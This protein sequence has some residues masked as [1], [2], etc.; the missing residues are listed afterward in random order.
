VHRARTLEKSDALQLAAAAAARPKEG[1]VVLERSHTSRLTRHTSKINFKIEKFNTK[2]V[3]TWR[4]GAKG[5]V[6]DP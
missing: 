3:A 4:G 1:F 2:G 5:Q 6:C